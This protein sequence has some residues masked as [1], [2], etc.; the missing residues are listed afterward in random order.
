MSRLGNRPIPVPPSVTVSVDGVNVIVKKGNVELSKPLL[1][2]V[3]V[4]VKDGVAKVSPLPEYE[5]SPMWG[6]CFSLFGAMVKGVSTGFSVSLD[7][8][9]VGYKAE[10]MD[11]FLLLSLGYSHDIFVQIP[12]NVSVKC[13]KNTLVVF[14]SADKKALGEFVSSIIRLRKRDPYKGKGLYKVGEVKRRKKG[15]NK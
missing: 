15:K 6:T 8:I 9:G 7:I 10:V 11:G 12:S 14:S 5:N 13:E 4:D 2:F 1:K 3:N